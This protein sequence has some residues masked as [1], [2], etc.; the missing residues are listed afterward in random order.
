[1]D[2]RELDLNHLVLLE[3]LFEEETLTRAAVRIG[4]SQPRSSAALAKLRAVIGDELFVHINGTMQ[5]TPR[6]LEL[7]PALCSV[8]RTIRRDILSPSSF[9][10]ARET[11]VFTLNT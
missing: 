11:G 2:L 7:R 3:A 5:P 4:F 1:M 10:P 8:L 9:D 6:A